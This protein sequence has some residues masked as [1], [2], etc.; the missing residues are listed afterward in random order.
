[1]KI[2]NMRRWRLK[3]LTRRRL[4]MKILLKKQ[5]PEKKNTAELSGSI[6]DASPEIEI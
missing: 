5:F 2:V 6:A 1:M 3:L 4:E